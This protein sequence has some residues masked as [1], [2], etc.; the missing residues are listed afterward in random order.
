MNAKD[1]KKML[2]TS[3]QFISDS[4]NPTFISFA[5]FDSNGFKLLAEEKKGLT[6]QEP[7][8]P[9]VELSD[10]IAEGISRGGEVLAVTEKDSKHFLLYF[11]KSQHFLCELRLPFFFNNRSI[12][13]LSLGKKESGTDYSL[14]EIDL[15]RLMVNFIA[16]KCGQLIHSNENN[17]QFE[18]TGPDKK[19]SA[20]SLEPKIKIR[21]QGDETGLLG[22]SPRMEYIKEL[23]EKIAAEDVSILIT[24]ES[25][26]GKELIAR[27]IHD[28]SHRS[29]KPLVAMN[30]AA[31]ADNL[32]ESELFG[33]E[34]GAFTGAY[35]QKQG[36]FEFA[37]DSTLFLDEIGDMSLP[38]QAKL[39]RVLQD[40]T[41]QRVGGNK[42]LHSDARLLAATNKDLLTQIEKGVFREDLFYRIN[43]VQIDLPPLRER[44]DDIVLITD[45]FFQY[46]N[47]YYRKNLTGISS[48]VYRWLLNY[49]FPGNIRELR[50][51]IERAV[52]MEHGD[53]ISIHHMPTNLTNPSQP[54]QDNN[55]R[56]SLEQ[57]EKE[58][59]RSIL[60][61]TQNN[62]SEAA[63]M[64]GIARKTLREKIQKYNL[65][66]I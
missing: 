46:Y 4:S 66:P 49:R 42:T 20:T 50:N 23:I 38:T 27:A 60:E 29:S 17:V 48:E 22:H 62:K 31:L 44:M 9:F 32:V 52:I 26:T 28:K 55:P 51:I 63:R 14:E 61:K 25:G 33:H 36:K 3:V 37:N 40:G 41:F 24:G 30:C 10:N 2:A 18:N 21:R 65:T 43:V 8:P 15:F 34:K 1:L 12:G 35:S 7:S 13:V 57:L 19:I 47:N 58:H 56:L 59:I 64:L 11:D 6:T 45:H 39:L 54:V 53:R 5:I 16:I